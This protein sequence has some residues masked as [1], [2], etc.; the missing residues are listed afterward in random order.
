MSVYDINTGS[1]VDGLMA[2]SEGA[3]VANYVVK[4][5]T[6]SGVAQRS[7]KCSRR[8]ARF[9]CSCRDVRMV[10]R[11][12][13]GRG[14]DACCIHR[15]KL[16]ECE[17]CVGYRAATRRMV[18]CACMQSRLRQAEDIASHRE[19]PPPPP[20]ACALPRRFAHKAPLPWAGKAL[21]LSNLGLQRSCM[22]RN[23]SMI[24]AA[25]CFMAGA[26]TLAETLKPQ[27]HMGRGPHQGRRTGRRTVRTRPAQTR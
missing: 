25:C 9:Q 15:D 19:Q 20:L 27:P 14:E 7:S 26:G 11:R 12:W 22:Q 1:L 17:G 18:P 21:V 24:A 3:A 6:K 2:L 8:T 4:Q 13:K 5:A 23:S 16:S 10:H